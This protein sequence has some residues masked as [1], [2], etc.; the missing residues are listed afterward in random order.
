MIYSTRMG[1]A[2]IMLMPLLLAGC[3]GPRSFVNS[4]EPLRIRLDLPAGKP[5]E[6]AWLSLVSRMGS[7]IPIESALPEEGRVV[8]EWSRTWTGKDTP[9]Y[10]VRGIA[11][12]STDRRSLTVE[13]PAQ[14]GSASR[15]KPGYDRDLLDVL[16]RGLQEDLGAQPPAVPAPPPLSD[17]PQTPKLWWLPRLSFWYPRVEG[18]MESEGDEETNIDFSE[19]LEFGHADMPR[20]DLAVRF[21]GGVS[22]GAWYSWARLSTSARLEENEVLNQ[23]TFARGTQIHSELDLKSWGLEVRVEVPPAADSPLRFIP[24]F[25]IEIFKANLHLEASSGSTR[26]KDASLSFCPGL[27]VQVRTQSPLYFAGEIR[28]LLGTHPGLE[29]GSGIG[30]HVQDG[31][32]FQAGWRH[33]GFD[34]MWGPNTEF[35]F[36]AGGAF[37]ELELSF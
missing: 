5:Y 13:A 14:S 15:A 12:F 28:M 19:D 24:S 17:D 26:H 4:R 23:Q 21:R 1:M 35:R 10:R 31:L 32:R 7:T 11:T 8:T 20:L 2:R 9:K 30:I 27:E 18:L 34:D 16:V 37:L 25:G 36:S 6:E 33:L 29:A 22:L 3:G